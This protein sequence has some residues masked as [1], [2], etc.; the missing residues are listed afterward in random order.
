MVLACP[1][2]WF[3][4]DPRLIRYAE[5][6]FSIVVWLCCL[7]WPNLCSKFSSMW[8]NLPSAAESLHLWLSFWRTGYL[9]NTLETEFL[10]RW[11]EKYLDLWPLQV[12]QAGNQLRGLGLPAWLYMWLKYWNS[13]YLG[14][15]SVPSHFPSHLDPPSNASTKD[16]LLCPAGSSRRWFQSHGQSQFWLVLD[17]SQ[18]VVKYFEEHLCIQACSIFAQWVILFTSVIS[19]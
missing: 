4:P 12:V 2:L 1:S 5:P 16:L 6:K 9:L 7:V 11:L 13:Y 18:L 17:C 3:H 14:H 8:H 10:Q 15:L 19:W